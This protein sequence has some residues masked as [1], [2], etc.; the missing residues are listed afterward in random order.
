M[1]SIHSMSSGEVGIETSPLD[2]STGDS[3]MAPM[4]AVSM[5]VNRRVAR[6]SEVTDR[7]SRS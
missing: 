7:R 1:W 4:K 6:N 2:T 3:W 5:V